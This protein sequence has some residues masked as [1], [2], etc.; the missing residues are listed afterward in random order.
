MQLY[1][2]QEAGARPTQ[3]VP[4]PAFIPNPDALVMT[5]LIG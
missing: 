5:T 3:T 2:N 1:A 4:A